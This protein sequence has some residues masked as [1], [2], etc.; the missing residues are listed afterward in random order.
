M[1][2]IQAVCAADMGAIGG[3]IAQSEAACTEL[4]CGTQV[5]PGCLAA[6]SAAGAHYDVCIPPNQF[7]AGAHL[8]QRMRHLIAGCA[9]GTAAPPPPV[10]PPPPAV[11]APTRARSPTFCGA[12]WRPGVWASVAATQSCNL[13]TA[14]GTNFQPITLACG[15]DI[16]TVLAN[17]DEEMCQSTLCGYSAACKAAIRTWSAAYASCMSAHPGEYLSAAVEAQTY[18]TIVARNGVCDRS[19]LYDLTMDHSPTTCTTIVNVGSSCRFSCDDGY[20]RSGQHICG[21]NLRFSGGSCIQP[22]CGDLG[23][24]A[25]AITAVCCAGAKCTAARPIPGTCSSPCAELL[26]PLARRCGGFLAEHMPAL[27]PLTQLCLERAGGIGSGTIE[28]AGDFAWPPCAH[29]DADFGASA[30]EA[31]IANGLSCGSLFCPECGGLA[32]KCDATCGFPCPTEGVQYPPGQPFL[33]CFEATCDSPSIDR[34]Q[35]RELR[36]TTHAVSVLLALR[37][38]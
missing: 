9:G 8:Y 21:S 23:Q 27:I 33:L 32:H 7:F 20:Q 16:K 36:L 10:P 30:C 4:L 2:T 15:E 22:D 34:G 1:L 24:S 28:P 14:P 31:S 19:C 6:L 38:L 37:V 12:E 18:G 29:D 11:V 25:E 3:A 35:V 17:A 5:A 13:G 26:A